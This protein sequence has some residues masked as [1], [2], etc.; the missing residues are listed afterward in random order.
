MFRG[1]L[2]DDGEKS[3]MDIHKV[4]HV[5]HLILRAVDMTFV[6]HSYGTALSS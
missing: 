3:L 1:S 4:H 5:F 2:G 6:A